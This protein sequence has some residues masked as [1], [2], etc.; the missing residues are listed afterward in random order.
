VICT[1]EGC[2][3]TARNKR[4]PGM[5]RLC[6]QRKL[7]GFKEAVYLPAAPLLEYADRVGITIPNRPNYPRVTLEHA[8]AICIDVL[9]VHPFEVYGDLYFEESLA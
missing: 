1:N 6:Y 5:C 8:D 9:G 4:K 7:F 3:R 2:N